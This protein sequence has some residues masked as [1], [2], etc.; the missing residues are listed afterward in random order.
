MS[1][2][3]PLKKINEKENKEYHALPTA[4]GL[5]M[6]KVFNDSLK[7][8]EDKDN[9]SQFSEKVSAKPVQAQKK[10]KQT[11]LKRQIN[12]L[13]EN[14]FPP[15]E[16]IKT[17]AVVAHES[18]NESAPAKKEKGK[19]T[20]QKDGLSDLRTIFGEKI[21]KEN[22]EMYKKLPEG[23]KGSYVEHIKKI[24]DEEVKKKQQ[25]EEKRQKQGEQKDQKSKIEKTKSGKK[26]VVS[27]NIPQKNSEVSEEVPTE[28]AQPKESTT[29]EKQ[30]ALRA[31][32]EKLE[33]SM[34]ER[35]P[36]KESGQ[37]KESGSLKSAVQIAM[38]KTSK[39]A[40]NKN[41]KEV[42]VPN[43]PQL[44]PEKSED[45]K[46]IHTEEN[47]LSAR[48]AAE[49]FN[50]DI[51]SINVER[52]KLNKEILNASPE[53]DSGKISE[54]HVRYYNEG[55][56]KNQNEELEKKAEKIGLEGHFRKLGEKYG[57]IGWK[58]KLGVGVALGVGAATLSLV[59]FP[60]AAA[61][62]SGLFAQRVAGMAHAFLGAEKF[63]KWN[64]EKREGSTIAK[65]IDKK[66][67]AILA[68]AV[69]SIGMG[70]GISYA[71][72]EVS[73]QIGDMTGFNLNELN[74][75]IGYLKEDTAEYRKVVSDWVKNYWPFGQTNVA[76]KNHYILSGNEK[77]DLN[78]A[79]DGIIKPPVAPASLADT[80]VQDQK[81]EAPTAESA[82]ESK[83]EFIKKDGHIDHAKVQAALNEM[84][85]APAQQFASAPAESLPGM[86]KSM[87]EIL[88]SNKEFEGLGKH[89]P[90]VDHAHELDNVMPKTAAL[91]G[92]D[93][94]SSFEN[95]HT[96]VDSAGRVIISGGE[97]VKERWDMAEALVK[98]D[99]SKVVYFE[100]T[101]PNTDNFRHVTKMSWNENLNDIDGGKGMAWGTEDKIINQFRTDEDFDAE[102]KLRERFDTDSKPG[103]GS[104]L[105]EHIGKDISQA[106][107]AQP[108]ERE[109]LY[110][111]HASVR[112]ES[113]AAPIEQTHVKVNSHNL[114]VGID[115]A[116]S[117][118]DEEG[119]RV[120]FGGSASEREVLAKEIVAKNHD[121]EVYFNSGDKDGHIRKV[122][123]DPGSDWSLNPKPSEIRIVETT[124][125]AIRSDDL[126]GAYTPTDSS[127][128]NYNSPRSSD[129]QKEFPSSDTEATPSL[130][131]NAKEPHIYADSRGDLFA[132]GG[133]P[134]EKANLIQEYLLKNPDRIVFGSNMYNEFRIPW[135]LEDKE[136]VAGLPLKDGGF[137]GFGQS[138]MHAPGPDEFTK[139]VPFEIEGR[140]SEGIIEKPILEKEPPVSEIKTPDAPVTETP[141]S[142][143]KPTVSETKTSASATHENKTVDRLE[144]HFNHPERWNPRTLLEDNYRDIIRSDENIKNP[145]LADSVVENRAS[146]VFEYKKL[147]DGLIEKGEGASADADQFRKSIDGIV[148]LTESRYGNVFKNLEVKYQLKK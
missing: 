41:K 128:D 24:H 25:K 75:F 44:R 89:A 2:G 15:E 28:T 48:P 58:S 121:A 74:T 109:M 19:T 110:H 16:T 53:T 103:L 91:E 57:K 94:G 95:L 93:L 127:R 105:K 142:E 83:N 100:S 85:K 20:E 6:K 118:T 50:P 3:N 108:V 136:V 14:I 8:E 76:E 131:I 29:L 148:K 51:L 11:V 133:T 1:E 144:N 135:H 72:K 124:G 36:S 143:E 122:F 55:Y 67:V 107:E 37:G 43:I 88:K 47:Q 117:Y 139:M 119:R 147:I 61:C 87:E 18:K 113:D 7:A 129:L 68:A 102:N 23:M 56:L 65:F 96:E 125:D 84:N 10:P 81:L 21:P 31:A 140:A 40:K 34:R 42:V 80:A 26:E 134:E 4:M 132:Y 106:Q 60:A 71:V 69:Y 66:E 32:V 63:L 120:I 45:T 59:S 9:Q 27:L 116:G 101:N 82:Q 77:L 145:S 38:E 73:Q 115:S 146:K 98:A 90:A 92:Q 49:K 30:A 112:V 99:H 104:V 138:W 12:N 62:M 64:V 97:S 111:S 141:A 78:T 70:A 35:R 17:K 137:F 52:N 13:V 39:Y 5:A 33:A 22:M 54:K 86:G 130:E 123:F 79:H 46:K 114:P 126:V